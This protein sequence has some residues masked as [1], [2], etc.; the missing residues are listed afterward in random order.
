[1]QDLTTLDV[2]VD[3]EA[4][5]ALYRREREKR[6][7]PDGS[8]QYRPMA[9]ELAHFVDDPYTPR[10][11]REPVHDHVEVAVLG[12][13]FGGL[14]LGARLREA[15]VEDLRLVEQGGDFGGTWYWNRYPGAA[16]DTEAY[17]YLPLLEEVGYVPTEKYV[18]GP[19]IFEH[20]RRIARHFDLYRSALLQTRVTDVSWDETAG[21]W[22]IETDRGDRF[23]AK[24]VCMTTGAM[25]KPKLPGVPGI[26]DFEGRAFHTTRWDYDYTGGA[27]TGGLSGLADK[28]VAVVGTGAT[29]IQAIPH[30]AASAQHTYVVQRTPS[31]VNVRANRP[32]D[33][34]WAAALEPGWQRERMRNFSLY[35]SGGDA[36]TDLVNDGWTAIYRLRAL[37]SGVLDERLDYLKMEE[38]R[39]RVDAVVKDPRTAAGLKPYYRALCKRPCFHDE[40]LD[41][42]NRPNVTLLDT[43][44]RGLERV[45]RTGIVVNGEEHPVD[46]I[47][48]ASGFTSGGP[49]ARRLGYDVHGPDG[50]ALS[51]KFKSGISTLFGMQTHGFP[52]FFLVAPSQVGVSSNQ[53]HVLDVQARHIAK[54]VA[55][56]RSRGADTVE[57]TQ[58]AEDQWVRTVIDASRA[59]LEFLSSCTPGYYNN[60]GNPVLEIF[61]RNG[62]Y[63]PGIVAFDDL[64]DDWHATGLFEGLA[65]K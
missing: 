7:H 15:G 3:L 65:F 5:R 37:G 54:I 44:G 42:F 11:E 35:V 46:C 33:P 9:D 39:A 19:E 8:A 21:L 62:A 51:E 30:V 60:E 63:S 4:V 17:I 58:E 6:I 12:G 52:N 32:T 25:S 43:E 23:T 61:R 50:L 14:L 1:M 29:G 18:K 31:S 16:C 55:E 20:S 36:E 28:R 64:L 56:A 27:P 10:V 24:Y 57:A 26:E 2:E 13:G 45:T 49:F 40:Y 53:T 34:A 38:I 59:D 22:T 41:A 48:F 47:I